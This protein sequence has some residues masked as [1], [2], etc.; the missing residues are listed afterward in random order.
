MTCNY[1]NDH[2]NG[3]DTLRLIEKLTM[4]KLKSKCLTISKNGHS[5]CH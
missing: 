3:F 4:F 2:A 1:D 5:H